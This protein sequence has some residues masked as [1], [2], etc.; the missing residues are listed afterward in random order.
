MKANK[1]YFVISAVFFCLFI[2]FTLM[3][4]YI[5]V[6]P[7]GPENSKVGFA[8]L[9]KAIS[10]SLPYNDLMYNLSEVLGYVAILTVGIFGLFGIMQLFIKKG[11]TKVDKDLYILCGLYACALLTYIVFEKVIINYRPVI[12][13]GE[14]EASYPSSHTMLAV[15]FMMAAIQQFSMRLKK[16]KSRQMV[17][18][19][20]ALVGIG[21]IITRI[22]SGVHWITDIIGSVLVSLAW[23]MLYLGMIATIYPDKKLFRFKD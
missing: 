9:N 17:L 7:V 1:K 18:I 13:E 14:L 12:L 22:I 6:A 21:V 15:T 19:A 11:F 4:K 3:V 16:E 5:G 10:D 20:C 23:F 2:I 8:T